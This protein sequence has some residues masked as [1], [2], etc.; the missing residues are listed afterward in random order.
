MMWPMV[1]TALIGFQNSF[2][3][4]F[5]KWL[6]F[7]VLF[8]RRESCLKEHNTDNSGAKNDKTLE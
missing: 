3:L 5:H 1:G 2:F 8:G 7:N 4:K 6:T